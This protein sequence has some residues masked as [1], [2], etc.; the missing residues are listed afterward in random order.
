MEI[1]LKQAVEILE[2]TPGVINQLVSGLS[3]DW[4]MMNR[5]RTPGVPMTLW[6]I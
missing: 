3:D 2:R 6:A 1:Q 5:G 4:V